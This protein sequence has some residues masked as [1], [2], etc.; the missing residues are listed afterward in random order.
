M[1]QTKSRIGRK[2]LL[3][4]AAAAV[5]LIA[6]GIPSAT[7]AASSE[8]GPAGAA[9]REARGKR[10]PEALQTLLKAQPLAPHNAEL[11]AQISMAWSDCA[12]VASNKATEQSDIKNALDAGEQ[13]L[14]ANPS[15]ANAHVAVAIACG[16][17]TDFVGNSR[18]MV[19]SK[20]I[21]DEAARARELDPK[22]SDAYYILGRW[23]YG[24][25]TLNPILKLAAR[26][27]Y[28]SM[29]PSSMEEAVQDLEKSV[30]LNPK[31]I[32]HR[33]ALAVAYQAAKQHDKA[34]QEWAAIL[35]LPATE[36]GDEQAKKEARVALGK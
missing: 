26:I 29:P 19:L 24:M 8:D 9:I 27:A 28:G 11:L 7:W 1:K 22:N 12:D 4:A 34:A 18:K 32:D 17:M 5:S 35:E 36:P 21:R 6:F 15:N 31:K 20:R 23:N 30:A 25:A 33:Q 14:R 3:S 10:P 2:C 16:K 13:A